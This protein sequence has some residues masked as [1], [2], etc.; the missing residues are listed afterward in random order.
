LIHFYKRMFSAVV[1]VLMTVAGATQGYRH[2]RDSGYGAPE[3]SY[4]APEPAYE[5]PAV[6]YAAAAPS[7]AAAAAPDLTPIIIGILVLTG[8]SLLFPTYVS[9]TANAGRRKR[10]AEGQGTRDA[11][12][13]AN[14]VERVQ[15]MYSAI[16]QSEECIER[17]ACE[18][19]GLASDAGISKSLTKAAEGFVPKKFNKMMKNF[20]HGK[21][22][23]KNNK[24][25]VF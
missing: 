12:P 20:N 10:S 4:G 1:L 6:E 8:L 18:V 13:L 7:Y 3:P 22:C 21:D 25:G 16:L 9:L 24:C 19:G 5:E 15:D 14:M 17:V 11:S 2:T 23:S